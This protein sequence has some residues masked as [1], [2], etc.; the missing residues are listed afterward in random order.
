VF[1]VLAVLASFAFVATAAWAGRVGPIHWK[2]NESEECEAGWFTSPVLLDWTVDSNASGSCPDVSINVDTKET[3]QTCVA[4]QGP[5]EIKVTLRIK[6]DQKP[7]E[8]DEPR[9]DRPADHAG[10]YTH[11]VSFA[12][13]ATDE[14]S[15]LDH[16][17]PVTYSGPDSADARVLVTCRDNAGNL[18]SR[19][20]P[21]RYDATA[22]DV[23]GAQITSGD[24]VV[25]LSWPAGATATVMRTP[26][27]DGTTSS[28]LY[29]GAGTGFTDREVRNRR[30]YRYVLTLTDEAGNDASR[31]LLAKPKPKL[32]APAPRAIVAAPPLLTW[33]AVRNA[34]YY[35]VQ[36]FRNG[37]KI[38]SVWPRVARYQLHKRWQFHG[39][40]YRLKPAKY[41]WHVWPGKGSRAAN[42]YGEKIG[43]RSFAVVPLGA[44]SAIGR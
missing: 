13:I 12:A 9:P 44:P 21:L 31:E 30:Q 43:K 25:R 24:R 15:G 14:T 6:L 23:S 34:R 22:P 4:Y 38:L 11:P 1:A 35:N 2:C 26:G 42:R 32:L 5:A 3:V 40:R 19:G 28:V 36:L 10:W 20:F 41:R 29:Q 16:C 7:P 18:A 37:R 27:I 17:D 39:K 8:I 33:T